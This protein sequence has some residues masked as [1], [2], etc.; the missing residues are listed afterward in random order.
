IVKFVDKLPGISISW[1]MDT[2]DY[3][4]YAVDQID[5]DDLTNA[6]ESYLDS[7]SS[8][9]SSSSASYSQASDVYI[10][11]NINY[12][13]GLSAFDDND[14]AIKMYEQIERVKEL[15]LVS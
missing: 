12:E 2:M 13:V 15:G 1:R 8:S 14:L 4:D 7:N 5:S 3:D 10:T 6:G 11:M 9:S